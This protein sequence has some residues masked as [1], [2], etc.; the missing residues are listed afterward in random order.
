M[1]TSIFVKNFILIDQV[2]L[3]FQPGLSAFTGETGAG[4]SL[5]MDAIGVLKGERANAG[6]V[7]TG[8][9]K[10]MIEGV[11]TIEHPSLIQKLTE[12]GFD[13][14]ED[15][16]IITREITKEGKSTTRINHRVASVSYVREIISQIVDIHSQHDT[17]YLLNARYHLGLLDNFVNELDLNAQVEKDYHA[18]KKVKDELEAALSSDYNE[19]DLEYLTFQLNEI[20]QAA[21]RQQELEALEDEQKRMLSFEKIT[22]A[23]QLAITQM[24]Q[25]GNPAVYET[26]KALQGLQDEVPS[27]IAST[28][29]DF[30]YQMEDMNSELHDYLDHLEYDEARFNEV[31]DRIFLIHKIYRKYGGDYDAVMEK[32]AEL[33]RKIDSILHRQDFILKHEAIVETAHKKFLASAAKLSKLRQKKAMELSTLVKQQLHDL[34]LEHARFEIAFEPTQG[35]TS[36]IDKVE[37]MVAMNAGEG[38]KPLAH[39]ASGG[40]LS[41]LM[42]GL[43]TVFTSLMGIE[44]VIFD[45]IDTGVSGK[46]A[47]AIG[48]KMKELGKQTQVFCVTHL[49][50]VAACASQHYIVEKHQANQ[51]T[52]TSIALLDQEQRIKELANIA[53]GS[54]SD[55]AIQSA[56]ELY[57]LANEE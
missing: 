9:D 15:A 28:L 41:R 37:F 2:S 25:T 27:R 10:A 49:A 34:Q 54:D 56:L 12:D 35:N 4:K 43:K 3:D 18:Y 14:E 13:L 16:L 17:Q 19:D 21:I 52:R 57:Q 55:H 11:F 48:K 46:V 38:L 29:S 53:S 7:K 30:Y 40:E 1:L 42:L 36:G 31:S 32:R 39:S 23:V 22:S 33:E 51:Q 44:T 50:P 6:M 20:D 47:L 45:E 24:E 5:L 8:C 26:F